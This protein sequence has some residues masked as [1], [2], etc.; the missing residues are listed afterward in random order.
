VVALTDRVVDRRVHAADPVGRTAV[1]LG[2]VVATTEELVA[3]CARDVLTVVD[4]AALEGGDHV[5][6]DVL[7]GTR[8]DGVRDVEAVDV[9]LGHPVLQL[10][11]DLVARAD[12]DGAHTAD[13]APGRD[14]AD[15][16][17]LA[18]L[19]G[20][21]ERGDRRLDGVALHV[22]DRL[23]DVVARGAMP[24]QPDMNTSAPSS[25]A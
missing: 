10:L 18:A 2:Q 11:G 19:R 17:L 7:E 3:Q 25:L 6:D 9:G 13:A 1:V 4:A 5:G 24:I 23:V 14:V 16:P 12:Q 21:L 8:G 20:L 22:A 15:A